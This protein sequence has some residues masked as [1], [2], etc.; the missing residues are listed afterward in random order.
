MHNLNTSRNLLLTFAILA[1]SAILLSSR[2][3]ARIP[4]PGV[5]PQAGGVPRPDHVLL[6]IEEN[7]SYSEIIGSSSAPYINTLAQQGALFTN[8]HGVE[9]P[10]EPNYLDLFSGSN[11]GVTNDNCPFTFSSQNLGSELIG[12][13]LAF[14]GYSEDLPAPG[15]TV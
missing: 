6:V 9:H 1:M 13:G 10:S 3:E 5:A 12:S 15:S 7:H 14:A 8:S 11:Q 2:A 4:D